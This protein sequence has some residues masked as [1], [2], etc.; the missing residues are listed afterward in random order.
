MIRLQPTSSIRALLTFPLFLAPLLAASALTAPA[1][2]QDLGGD[3]ERSEASTGRGKI[4]C[5]GIE[6]EV[7]KQ[8]GAS[9][10]Q[11]KANILFL[12][13]GTVEEEST[14][15]VFQ[16]TTDGTKLSLTTVSEGSQNPFGADEMSLVYD[17]GE[18]ED[19]ALVQLVSEQVEEGPTVS[20]Y[21]IDLSTESL[22]R[23]AGSETLR[24][25]GGGARFALSESAE[26]SIQA[27]AEAVLEAR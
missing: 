13:D 24:L 20:M 5:P 1:Q 22:R 15:D 7:E 14:M 17:D 19:K 11:V 12:P 4:D 2:A 21:W 6:L 10:M 27:Q 18:K 3:C 25:E 26:G 9:L 23:L 16:P 8:S